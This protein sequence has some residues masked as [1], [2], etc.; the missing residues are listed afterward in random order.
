MRH[1][2]NRDLFKKYYNLL[3]ASSYVMLVP[4][5][6]N[7]WKAIFRQPWMRPGK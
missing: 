2:R 5:I 7:D 3:T 4:V 1:R 6:Q